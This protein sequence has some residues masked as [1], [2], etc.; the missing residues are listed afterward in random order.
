MQVRRDISEIWLR[1]KHQWQFPFA[2]ILNL[3]RNKIK[4]RFAFNIGKQISSSLT[5]PDGR[6][7]HYFHNLSAD[8]QPGIREAEYL[9]ARYLNHEFNLLGSGW[10]KVDY[11]T[12]SKGFEQYKYT[13]NFNFK[14]FDEEYKWLEEVIPGNLISDALNLL[15]EVKAIC[16]DYVFIDWQRDFISGGR[17]DA[18]LKHDKQMGLYRPGMDIK[19]PWEL[20]RL[21]HLPQ[22]ACW[23]LTHEHLSEKLYLEFK[24]Q[25]LDFSA[26]NPV[27]YGANWAC[28]MDVGIR[29]ANLC[30]AIDIFSGLFPADEPWLKRCLKI[31]YEHA[32][33]IAHHF[34]YRYDL[35][36]NHYLANVAGLLFACAY[37]PATA[38]TNYWLALAAQEVAKAFET[39]FLPDGGNFEQS[40]AYHRLSGEMIVWSFALIRAL[41]DHQKKAILNF[42]QRGEP[43]EPVL[44]L[45]NYFSQDYPDFIRPDLL[46][47]LYKTGLFSSAIH[48]PDDEILQ[49]GDNDSGRFLRLT[50]KGKML[51][52]GEAREHYTN[53]SNELSFKK[54]EEYW[55]ENDLQHGGFLAAIDSFFGQDFF[56]PFSVG[57]YLEKM[58][59]NHLVAQTTAVTFVSTP[60]SVSDNPL[61]D[62]GGLKY[63]NSF[64]YS[65]PINHLE[66]LELR[67]FAYFGLIVLKHTDFFLSLRLVP[68]GKVHPSGSHQHMDAGSVDLWHEGKSIWRDPGTYVYTSS[69]QKRQAFRDVYAHHVPHVAGYKPY[70]LGR[71]NYWAFNLIDRTKGALVVASTE[72]LIYQYTYGRVK[73]QRSVF[74]HESGVKIIDQSNYPF[75]TGVAEFGW[76][77]PGYGKLINL[78]EK[79]EPPV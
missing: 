44:I 16:P 34:E 23:A 39:Q 19:V 24:C 47:K 48:K 68:K 78:K 67:V 38:E 40:T 49:I 72:K 76:F 10:Q 30:V 64:D 33:H 2:F 14:S 43:E 50:P 29:T 69:G 13:L 22:M 62:D 4:K 63:E 1:L 71:S 60:Q 45:H 17:F 57:F 21:Q 5:F 6:L 27:G 35:S 58:L 25:I 66:N 26:V 51:N 42:G 31:I 75:E 32:L 41:D 54:T 61:F 46:E 70:Q 56:S 7:R 59:M 12:P 8:I 65:A 73:V 53:L 52:Y 15:Q 37:L 9:V 74:I 79:S 3:A 55:D 18:R 77:S 28:T 11:F 36:S 20:G